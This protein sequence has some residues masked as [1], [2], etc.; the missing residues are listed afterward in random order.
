MSPTGTS[1]SMP[2][3]A[4]PATGPSHTHVVSGRECVPIELTHLADIDDWPFD[5][6]IDVRSPSEYAEDRVPGAVNLPV[7]DDEERARVG[8]IY[9]QD[10]PFKARKLG[11]A[12][13]A[14]NAARHIETVLA[15]HPKRYRPLIYCWRG[16]QRSGAF[17]TIL[18]QIGWRADTLSGGYRSYRRLVNAALYDLPVPHR[19]VILDGN[20]GTAKT[21]LLARLAARGN[22]VLDL[23]GLARHRGSL[24]G[25][26]AGG[27]PAQK[28]FESGV[29]MA[30]ARFD[31]AR[32]VL[33]EAESAKVGDRIV[34]PSVWAAM[35]RA[36]RLAVSAPLGARAAYLVEAYG[37][38]AA[39]RA[40][41]AAVLDR[42][43]AYHGRETVAAW[44][45][46]LEA[47]S[48]QALASALMRE[49]YDPRYA[50]QRARGPGPA[51]G[52][53]DLPDL[54]VETRDAA[55]REIERRLNPG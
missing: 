42:L 14:R 39:D 29:A 34:P 38:L 6:I 21:D 7:L 30:L 31:P 37:E 19:F 13:V 25:A 9:V 16:G 20:T 36:P 2:E 10:S 41:F 50:R 22:Q 53:I 52:Q 46:L 26:Q 5:E 15:G 35:K 33:V 4:V 3:G 55:C 43:V 23:E 17:A 18:S 32:P 24:F 1:M 49:H 44:Q 54:S 12:L 27:Q 48:L 51:L 8:T 40:A 11:A 45:A 47:G 28:D